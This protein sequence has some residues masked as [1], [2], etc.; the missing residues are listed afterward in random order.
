MVLLFVAPLTSSFSIVVKALTALVHQTPTH[1][2]S[3][4]LAFQGREGTDAVRGELCF[5]KWRDFSFPS[6]FLEDDHL[7][8]RPDCHVTVCLSSLHLASVK[9]EGEEEEEES[10]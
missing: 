3:L 9:G 2:F 1:T 4:S 8:L 6:S 5:V 10:G 7:L